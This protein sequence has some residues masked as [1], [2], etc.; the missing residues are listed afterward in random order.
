VDKLEELASAPSACAASEENA[1]RQVRRLAFAS[2]GFSDPKN[3]TPVELENAMRRPTETVEKLKRD[4][5]EA[6]C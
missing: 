3:F 4:L 6:N 5:S 2:R 1:L